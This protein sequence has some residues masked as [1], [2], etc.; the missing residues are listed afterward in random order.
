MTREKLQ[1]LSTAMLSDAVG[2]AG[3]AAPGFV[4]YSGAGTR[5]GRAVTASCAE[6]SL[7]PVFEAIECAA[8]GDFL[9]ILGPGNTAYLGE[10]LAAN[11]VKR[12]LSGAVI[13][14]FARDRE[15]ISKMPATFV[16][17]GLTPVNLRRHI[18]G[19]AMQP[20]ILGGVSVLPGDWIV[21][22]DDGVIA[23]PADVVGSAIEKAQLAGVIEQR[24][25]TLILEHGMPVP[26]AVKMALTES[27]DAAN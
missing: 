11:I 25:R 19:L 13:D 24:I 14:G 2:G 5:A 9:C 17:K 26:Q 27:R 3:V 23:I 7:L 6:G 21:V 8:E 12:G 15:A 10:L 20:I 16:A 1:A 4:R 18:P 22:D